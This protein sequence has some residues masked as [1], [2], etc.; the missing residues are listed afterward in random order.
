MQRR[1][2]FFFLVLS[3]VVGAAAAADEKVVGRPAA[4]DPEVTPANY[5]MCPETECG[6]ES[7]GGGP[8]NSGSC[9]YY[10]C[11][12]SEPSVLPYWV[13]CPS[14]GDY[15]DCPTTACYYRECIGSSCSISTGMCNACPENSGSN[16]HTSSC[17]QT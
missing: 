11:T 5:N 3:L 13:W 1:L 9:P 10:L 12:N 6:G 2:A 15:V 17:P 8:G 14:K 4:T 7:G 16:V